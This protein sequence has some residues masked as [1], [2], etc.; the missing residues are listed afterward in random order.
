MPYA[1]V[2]QVG[3]GGV[4]LVDQFRVDL[5]ADQRLQVLIDPF[6]GFW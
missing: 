4:L 3:V 2:Y 6:A 1:Q 5:L